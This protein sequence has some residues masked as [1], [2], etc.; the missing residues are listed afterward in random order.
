MNIK[1]DY[2]TPI[3][4]LILNQFGA[5][6]LGIMLFMASGSTV[7]LTIITSLFSIGFYMVITYTSMWDI[8]SKDR[9]KFDGGRLDKNYF[10]IT[11]AA[12]FANIPNI[13]LGLICVL[14]T[15]FDSMKNSAVVLCRI[16]ILFWESM[17]SGIL[18]Y[19][20]PKTAEGAYAV[21]ANPK[22]TFIMMLF[23]AII[24]PSLVSATLGYIAGFNN[25]V[26]I[27]KKKKEN[28]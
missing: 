20:M 3:K 18:W 25:F 22:G 6:L 1:Y 10:R 17:Y 19:L 8:G 2:K 11:K 26:I 27:P 15:A 28:K 16:I 21:V 23:L 24:I 9:L 4:K 13:I 14:C 7:W 5:A 12:L